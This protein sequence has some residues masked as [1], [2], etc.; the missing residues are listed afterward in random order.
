MR[1]WGKIIGSV[2][3][4]A[5]AGPIGGLTGIALGALADRSTHDDPDPS[6]PRLDIE[7]RQ[8]DDDFGRTVQLFFKRDVPNGAVAVSLL[9]DGR[10]RTLQAIDAFADQ[11]A[12]VSHRAI[13]RGR[14]EFYVPFS[15]L[16]YRRLGTYRLRTTVIMMSPGA[17]TPTTL[18]RQHFDF[19]LPPPS[20]WSR[21][22]FILPLMNLC[23]VIL[24]ADGKPSDRGAKIIQKFFND[25]FDLPRRERGA[26]RSLIS[27][28]EQTEIHP[29]A[30]AVRR[31][32]P[33]LKPTD[34]VA[35][36]AEVARCDGPPSLS[37]RR[38]IKDIGIYLGIPENRWNEV[39]AKLDLQ[40]KIS[41]PWEMLGIDRQ[42]TRVDIK[43]AYRTK[44][45]GLHPDKVARMDSEIQD[46][47]KTRTVEL[48]EAYETVLE[49]AH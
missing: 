5:I 19:V 3:G 18:G 35:L 41:D 42:A 38:K 27:S 16:K 29:A 34:I 17:D 33:A 24:Y 22:T 32:M 39:E 11:G 43:R 15:A 48:R 21:L 49:D 47:A 31:R 46:L 6:I 1:V 26:L 30:Q 37:A 45:A 14:V 2:A 44:L 8:I 7:V 12:F 9:L 4:Y 25:S 28:G 36:L 20:S 13:E 10:G 40:T 23:L